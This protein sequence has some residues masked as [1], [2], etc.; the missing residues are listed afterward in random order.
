MANPL[1]SPPEGAPTREKWCSYQAPK[2]HPKSVKLQ[3]SAAV[4]STNKNKGDK[5]GKHF[6]LRSFSTL[7]LLKMRVL[8]HTKKTHTHTTVK[9]LFRYFFF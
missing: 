9:N 3:K 7:I 2:N 5:K 6:Q 8:V 4:I 1:A